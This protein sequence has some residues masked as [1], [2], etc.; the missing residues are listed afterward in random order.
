MFSKVFDSFDSFRKNVVDYH[1][2]SEEAYY[3]IREGDS[4]ID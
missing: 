3:K 4:L 2:I 1:K